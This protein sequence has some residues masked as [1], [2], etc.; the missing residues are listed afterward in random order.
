MTSRS[1]LVPTDPYYQHWQLLAKAHRLAIIGLVTFALVTVACVKW[2]LPRLEW[3]RHPQIVVVALGLLAYLCALPIFAR[4]GMPCP[5]CG[6][7][8]FIK[9]DDRGQKTWRSNTLSRHCLNCG[10]AL[11]SPG[12]L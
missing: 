2:L 7:P 8:F 3:E 4:A 10:L 12:D 6:A 9:V 11:W 1:R 5:R